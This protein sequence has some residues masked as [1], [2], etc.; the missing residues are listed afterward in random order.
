MLVMVASYQSHQQST[1]TH[2]S[3]RDEDKWTSEDVMMHV[4]V[5]TTFDIDL[6]ELEYGAVFDSHQSKGLSL[7]TVHLWLD[8]D[9]W[10][11]SFHAL[12]ETLPWEVCLPFEVYM[13]N[14]R[15][16]GDDNDDNNNNNQS[17]KSSQIIY[18]TVLITITTTTRCSAI[19]EIALQGAL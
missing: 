15:R 18:G 16:I 3:V 5:T 4:A 2:Q 9:W 10:W 6:L 14:N 12:P 19:A 7:R 11:L 1:S 13:Q 17:I 8:L